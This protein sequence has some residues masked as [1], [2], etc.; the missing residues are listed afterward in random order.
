MDG[1]TVL[2]TIDL[3]TEVCEEALSL[4]D[5]SLI[6]S[7][8]PPIF[9]GLKKITLANTLQASLLKLSAKGISVFAPHTSLDAIEG[10]INTFLSRPFADNLES[11]TSIQP[12]ELPSGLEEFHGAGMGRLL[13]LKENMD[14]GDIVSKVK[15]LLGLKYGE[16]RAPTKGNIHKRGGSARADH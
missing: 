15:G 3:T 6:V 1:K 16:Y 11:S 7:Y 5:C 8:H 9:S 4:P 10:G 14:L 12:K 2:L 13:T